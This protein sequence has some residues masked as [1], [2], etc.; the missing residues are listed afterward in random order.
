MC[1]SRLQPSRRSET[2]IGSVFT[3]H[4]KPFGVASGL[5]MNSG[6]FTFS[7]V[8]QT[9]STN[10]STNRGQFRSTSRTL[11]Y[12]VQVAST[13]ANIDHHCMFS[14]QNRTYWSLLQIIQTGGLYSFKA[15][16]AGSNPAALTTFFKDLRRAGKLPFFISPQISPQN[17][18]GRLSPPRSGSAREWDRNRAVPPLYVFRQ[19]DPIFRKVLPRQLR[20]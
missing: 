8:P 9:H 18:H 4:R 5:G 19:P 20:Q 10:H 12:V 2:P 3:A 17:R 13:H 16:V 6:A 15:W 7:G 14:G 1:R 11:Q